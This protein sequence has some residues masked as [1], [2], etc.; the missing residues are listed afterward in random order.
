MSDSV[1]TDSTQPIKKREK[2]CYIGAPACFAL[3]QAC[4]TVMAAFREQSTK[5]HI[6]MYIVGSCLE[7]PDFRDVDVR[8]IMDD[9]S[10]KRLFPGAYTMQAIW[11]FNPRWCLLTVAISKWL[12]DQTGLPIDFQFQPQTFANEKHPGKRHAVGLT[13]VPSED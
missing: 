11:E 10:F 6:G 3:E 12:S 2:I 4:K 1:K 5:D 13:F 8:L 7:R 9:D